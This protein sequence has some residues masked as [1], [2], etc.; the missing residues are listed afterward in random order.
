MTRIKVLG[1]N[2]SGLGS[3]DSTITNSINLTVT[4]NGAVKVCKGALSTTRNQLVKNAIKL[5]NRDKELTLEEK[6]IALQNLKEKISIEPNGSI[7]KWRQ[8]LGNLI[9]NRT[10]ALDKTINEL[11]SERTRKI[12]RYQSLWKS[13]AAKWLKDKSCLSKSDVTET[14]IREFALY[15]KTLVD[16]KRFIRTAQGLT[17]IEKEEAIIEAC[18]EAF[19]ALPPGNMKKAANLEEMYARLAI[20]LRSQYLAQSTT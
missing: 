16:T 7:K 19:R 13:A 20:S 8:T 6:I 11:E 10:K 5:A 12:E 2:F 4:K 17:K 9:Y 15:S 18:K 1:V 14:K 3:W